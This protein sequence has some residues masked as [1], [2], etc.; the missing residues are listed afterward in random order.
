MRIKELRIKNYRN[1]DDVHVNFGGQIL[2]FIVGE[3]NLGKTNLLE[4]LEAIFNGKQFEESDFKD[5]GK[6]IEVE[7]TLI[8]EEFEVGVFDD[9]MSPNDNENNSNDYEINLFIEQ[10]DPN[11]YVKVK[12]KESEKEIEYLKLKKHIIFLMYDSLRKPVDE[13]SFDKQKSGKKFL[14]YISEKAFKESGNRTLLETSQ[15]Q[16]IARKI[17]SYLEHIKYFKDFNLRVD[18]TSDELSQVLS[19]L[20]I[21]DKNSG[22]DISNTG[23]GIQ[24][25]LMIYL[26]ILNGI[27]RVLNPKNSRRKDDYIYHDNS[28]N[29]K[30]ISMIL[31]IDEPEIHLHPYMQRS[32]I[33]SINKIINNEDK[34]FLNLIKEVFDIDGIKGQVIVVTHS[35][36]ILL[37]DYKQ[38]IRVYREGNSI[39]FISPRILDTDKE[40]H[41]NRHSHVIKEAMFSRLVVIVEGDTELGAI[42][43]FFENLGIDLD[44]YGITVLKADGVESFGNIKEVLNN[45]GIHCITFADRDT[46]RQED[47]VHDVVTSGKDFEEDVVNSL[48]DE[49]KR[50][51]CEKLKINNTDNLAKELRDKKNIIT[52]KIIAE[53]FGNKTECIP[54]YIKKLAQKVKE[55]LGIGESIHEQ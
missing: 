18:Y 11:E 46:N 26:H 53:C 24:Y 42:P 55:K 47:G 23:Y 37:N 34:A 10:K 22:L 15:L 27:T 51:I 43:I 3:N 1:F 32:L 2:S 29:K 44:E 7:L 36:N 16:E 13:L 40:K 8:M 30:Y 33:K 38:Y 12:H 21:V 39:K 41:L 19:L 9:L 49:I 54:E 17:T 4:L 25:T 20:S 14:Y 28:S 31:A 6:P 35:P 48:E 45:F 50:C 5:I 52:G